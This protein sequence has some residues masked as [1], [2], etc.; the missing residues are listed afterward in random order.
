VSEFTGERV[1]P[2]AVDPDLWNEH[3]SRYAFA[4]R[5]SEGK[6]V[7]DA[8]CGT[9]YGTAE[10]SR[11]AAQAVG[12]DISHDAI[13]YGRLHY[14][15]ENMR[16]LQASCTAMPFREGSFDLVAAFE[17]IE[18][19]RD[20]RGFLLE[21]RRVLTAG[22]QCVISTPNK[23][24]YSESRGHTGANPYHEHEF[25]FD[26]FRQELLS[27]FPHVSLFLQNHAEGFVF[28]PANTFSLPEARVESA[29]GRPEDSHFFLAVCAPAAQT[30]ARTFFYLPRAA[31][32]LRER[33][34]HIEKLEQERD[35]LLALLRR[36]NEELEESNRWAADLNEELKQAGTLIGKLQAELQEQARGYEAKIAELE[37]D[38]REK[39]EW[40]IRNEQ[41]AEER[42]KW[43][44]DLDRQVHELAG[45]LSLVRASRW[46]KLGN[47]LGIGPRLR[48]G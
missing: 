16:F 10:L 37:K 3:F 15:L 25:T 4:A 28:Q 26:E 7:L 30:G 21:L 12:L 20:W 9:G 17:V 2:G 27:V 1:I 31:N 29:A 34:R 46:V 24:Y 5:L 48:D 14:S 32:I 6:R 39:A 22:G 43:A 38:N 42:T 23:D 45:R 19:L 8:G 44:L 40:A 41:T 47:T 13:N 18:H 35:Q 11:T 36:Q 33:E